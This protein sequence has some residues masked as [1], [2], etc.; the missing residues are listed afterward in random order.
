MHYRNLGQLSVQVAHWASQL[1]DDLEAIVGIPRSGLLAANLLALH[2]NLP[3]A[4]ING[5]IQGRLVGG[6]RRLDLDEEGRFL[7]RRRKVLVVDDSVFTGTEMRRAKALVRSATLP[8]DILYGAVY[9]S[10]NAVQEVDHYCEVVPMPRCFQWN[11]MH[12]PGLK[13]ACVDIDGVLCRDPTADENDDGPSYIEFLKSVRPLHRPTVPLYYVVTCRLEKYRDLTQDWLGRHNIRYERLVMMQYP[14]MISRRK[15][16]AYGRFKA[17]VFRN[18]DAEFFIESSLTQA[19]EIARITRLPVVCLET[20][21]VLYGESHATSHQGDSDLAASVVAGDPA[22]PAFSSQPNRVD[23]AMPS[24]QIP[25]ST[26]WRMWVR[27]GRRNARDAHWPHNP[28]VRAFLRSVSV[29]ANGAQLVAAVL[30]AKPP[31]DRSE[32]AHQFWV[33]VGMLTGASQL[34]DQMVQRV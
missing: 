6:G 3:L 30:R 10:P 15:A 2:L 20:H 11:I 18:S 24:Y 34:D 32:A 8:H 12:H 27:E 4:D 16:N 29:L 33:A 7:S 9:V 5:L 23:F 17:D 22:K 31:G 26:Q 13:R 1:P 14:D 21:D 19:R 25:A 28:V